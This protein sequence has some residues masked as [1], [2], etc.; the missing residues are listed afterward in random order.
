MMA[1]S[2]VARVISKEKGNKK[3]YVKQTRVRHKTGR[4]AKKGYKRTRENSSNGHQ[5]TPLNNQKKK[6]QM[7]NSEN[8]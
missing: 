5:H 4:D 1:H 8:S 2:V 3:Q 6:V 7:S